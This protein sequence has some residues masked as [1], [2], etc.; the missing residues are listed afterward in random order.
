MIA[1]RTDGLMEKEAILADP[2]PGVFHIPHF[3][4]YAAVLVE[5]GRIGLDDLRDIL[6]DGWLAMAPTDLAERHAADGS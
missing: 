4:G 2:P 6:F 5:L 1:V 3:K